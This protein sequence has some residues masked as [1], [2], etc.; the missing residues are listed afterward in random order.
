MNE[1]RKKILYLSQV[2]PYPN[3]GGGKIKTLNSLQALAQ[4]FEVYAIFISEK[5][6]NKDELNYLKTM[7]VKKIKVFFNEK[8]L[9]SVKDDYPHLIK[10]F[11]KLNPHYVF[12]YTHKPASTFIIKT[13]GSYNPDI[14]HVDHINIAQYLPKI[15]K[16]TWIL[17]H[18]NLE[19]YLLWTRFIHSSKISRKLY[20]LIESSL[21]FLFESRVI[22]KFDHVFAI[23]KTEAQR[24]K[25]FFKIKNVS[26]QPLVYL[27]TNIKKVK[28]KNPYILFIGGLGWPPNEDAIEWFIKKMFPLIIKAIP[29]VELHIVG[30]D[31]P[32]F[33]KT[34]PIS[35]NIFLHGYQKNLDP[36]LKKAS[37]FILPFRMGG[38]V[39]LKAL[40]A[41]SAG[42]PIVSTKLGIEGIEVKKNIH[43]IEANSEKDFVQKTV[44]L[45]KSNKIQESISLQQKKYIK[46]NHS[47]KQN[48]KWLKDYKKIVS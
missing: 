45:L 31:N 13:I 29:N 38:G 34:L 36:F 2:Y 35:K 42:I 25:T 21:T 10:N 46:E 33:T 4:K 28:T 14:I 24:I 41:L 11:L 6:P 40:T 43:Y 48:L 32:V 18:H 15:K 23:S 1:K 19:F 3:D 37:I 17:E 26:S 7:G 9:D 20:L 22:K 47:K 5:K 44:R 30:K 39:R 8:I 16:E 27:P 12:Q